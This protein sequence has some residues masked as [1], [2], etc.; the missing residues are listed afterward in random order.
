M[1]PMERVPVSRLRGWCS[2]RTQTRFNGPPILPTGFAAAQDRT[3]RVQSAAL[4]RDRAQ[5]SGLTSRGANWE[6]PSSGEF[7]RY[8]QSKKRSGGW[9]RRLHLGSIGAPKPDASA[10][11][12][13]FFIV[14]PAVVLR[15][16]LQSYPTPLPQNLAQLY[17]GHSA[18][19]TSPLRQ[20]INYLFSSTYKNTLAECLRSNPCLWAF[21]RSHWAF[22]L[23]VPCQPCSSATCRA[24]HLL[25]LAA[26]SCAS[27]LIWVRSRRAASASARAAGCAC[28]APSLPAQVC[29]SPP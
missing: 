8:L 9:W 7:P 2:H 20:T 19:Q 10:E 28:L 14:A 18:C 12:N 25:A 21:C 5:G 24:T 16:A 4:L 11:R 26:H 1:H 13:T 17:S 6:L 23:A 15:D 3:W 27:G 22:S 29:R